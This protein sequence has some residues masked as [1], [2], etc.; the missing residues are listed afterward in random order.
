MGADG[1]DAALEERLRSVLGGP[2]EGRSS[3]SE[4]WIDLQQMATLVSR[5]VR[6]EEAL[7]QAAGSVPSDVDAALSHS[8]LHRLSVISRL[9]GE[10]A[11]A[12]RATY[13]TPWPALA[14][15]VTIDG[16]DC[17]DEAVALLH[18]VARIDVERRRLLFESTVEPVVAEKLREIA[19]AFDGFSGRNLRRVLRW[20]SSS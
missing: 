17:V 6:V 3:L 20:L 9:H 18:E 15:E 19:G 7:F 11:D 8:S 4:G 12:V 2:W 16:A 10:A 13:P 14:V 1:E 5:I